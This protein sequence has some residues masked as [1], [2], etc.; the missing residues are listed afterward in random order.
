LTY[1]H[2]TF[3]STSK[4]DIC[5]KFTIGHRILDFKTVEGK[6]E[7]KKSEFWDD[8]EPNDQN[9]VSIPDSI[10]I[11]SAL[12][13]FDALLSENS[14]EFIKK[15][16]SIYISAKIQLK[17]SIGGDCMNIIN[18]KLSK[19]YILINKRLVAPKEF[20]GEKN[21]S[22]SYSYSVGFEKYFAIRK[23]IKENGGALG[24][25]NR[26]EGESGNKTHYYLA[27]IIIKSQIGSID[28][29]QKCDIEYMHPVCIKYEKLIGGL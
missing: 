1:S 11:M 21:D 16:P 15:I 17:F 6:A 23:L 14:E 3:Q 25:E 28:G 18:A 22:S 13:N 27:Q 2:N 10:K 26:D 20:L 29:K 5:S 4:P 19:E 24:F 12:S 7:S 8:F 9:A